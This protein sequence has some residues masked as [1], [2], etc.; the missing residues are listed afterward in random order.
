MKILTPKNYGI[1]FIFVAKRPNFPS[2]IL[3]EEKYYQLN[4]SGTRLSQLSIKE[5]FFLFF[6]LF[7][8]IS[9]QNYDTVISSTQHPL[10]SKFAFVICKILNIEFF[11][12]VETWYHYHKSSLLRMYHT[13]T[14]V[15]IRKADFCL[16]NGKAAKQH[17]LQKKVEPTKIKVF[18]LITGDPLKIITQ[19]QPISQK[20]SRINFAFVGR[21]VRIKGVHVLI[22]AFSSLL[23]KYA[24]INLTI[25]GEGPEKNNLIELCREVKIDKLVN[26][27]GWLNHEHALSLLHKHQIFVFPSIEHEGH[28]EGFGLALVE[29]VGLGLAVIASDAVGASYDL[30][31]NG[32]NGYVV[33]NN[34]KKDLVLAIE[35]VIPHYSQ[36]GKNSRTLFEQYFQQYDQVLQEITLKQ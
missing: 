18:P 13:I 4:L 2:E 35:K 20:A 29:A 26:F 3:N 23:L 14:D 19:C 21:L 33:K 24:N 17:L 28:K 34:S 27:V 5:I 22:N 8:I 25:I 32:Y 10:H 6:K 11:V 9:Q 7:K 36:M 12:R 30:V 15:I 16:V 31:I 1:D